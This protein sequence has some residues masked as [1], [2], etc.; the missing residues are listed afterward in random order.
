MPLALFIAL[1]IS[2]FALCLNALIVS[3]AGDRRSRRVTYSIIV[4]VGL[5]LAVLLILAGPFIGSQ[6]VSNSPL[7]EVREQIVSGQMSSAV[8]PN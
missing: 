6:R 8:P 3:I 7:I 5:D 1:A 4:V 2:G